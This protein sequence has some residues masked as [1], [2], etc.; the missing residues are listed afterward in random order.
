MDEKLLKKNIQDILELRGFRV[1]FLEATGKTKTPDLEVFGDS[2]KYTIE[3]KIK[4]EDNVKRSKEIEQLIKGEIVGKAEPI[5]PRNKLSSVV[6]KGKKQLTEYDPQGQTYRMIWLHSSGRNPY[7]QNTRFRATLFGLEQLISIRKG[8]IIECY[9]FHES[10]FYTYRD[11]LDG[12]FL[13]YISDGQF[14]VQLCI[15]SQSLS[16]GNF[17]KSELV[18]AFSDALNDPDSLANSDE[19][20]MIADCPFD[21]KNEAKILQYLQQKYNLNHLQTMPLVS[22][23]AET[24]ELISGKKMTENTSPSPSNFIE[25]IIAADLQQGKNNGA[26]VTRFP[27]EPNGYLHIGHAKSICLNFGLA[28]QFQGRCNLRFDDTNPTKEEEEYVQSIQ[29]DVRWLGFDWGASALYASDYFEQLYAWAVQLIKASKAYVCDLNSEEVRR[30]RGTLTEPGAQSPYRNRSVAENLDLFER[31]QRGE[32]PDG[33]RTLRAKIDMAS[34]NLNL[35]D[36]VMYRILKAHH[37]RTG[38]QWSIYP[39]YDYAHGQ[40]D[41]IEGITHSICTLEFEDHR[42]LY[43]WFLEQLG[44]HHP[45]QIEFARLNLTYTVMSKRKLLELV[46]EGLVRGWDDPRMPT[47]SGLRRRGYT[48]EA[49]RDFADR[50]GVAKRESTVDIALLEHC[51]RED[52]N[53]RAPRRMAVLRPLKV[54]IENYPEGQVEELEAVNNPEDPSAGTR[55]LPFARELYIEQDDF[56]EEPPPKYHRLSVGREVRLRYAYIIKCEQVVKDSISGEIVELRCSYY[57]DSLSDTARK[58][59]ATVHWVSARHAIEAEVR[60]YDNL[61]T[62]EDPGDVEEGSDWKEALNPNSLETLT[63]CKLEPAL[64]GISAGERCQF[65]RLGY[66]CADPDST[67]EHPVFNRT[68]G[69]KNSWGRISKMP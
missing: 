29:E 8:Y 47:L 6:K 69:L 48:P 28:A 1:N 44:V 45:Q 2:D 31:M 39:M 68:V 57:P 25:Q 34:P 32:F 62:Q 66:F 50:I 55:R 40:S 26:V 24:W 18:A 30:S 38:D 27:P 61:F 7:L 46:R 37:H 58:V 36:P 10:I 19:N 14:N 13:T 16:V 43:D 49:I 59:K 65:E 11:C 56:R 33:S 21:R 5:G 35:R 20:V 60:L 64:K 63:G 52:L 3:L 4:E 12:A 9:Y 54:I 41:S 22:L 53:K 51:L 67:P 17:K 42:P 23:S 15:N